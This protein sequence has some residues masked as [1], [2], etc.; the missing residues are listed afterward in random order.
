MIKIGSQRDYPRVYPADSE[1]VTLGELPKDN[2][3]FKLA[4]MLG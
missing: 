1:G 3:R 2:P 4:T